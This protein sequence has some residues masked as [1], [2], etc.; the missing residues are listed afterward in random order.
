MFFLLFFNISRLR[1][2]LVCVLLLSLV[3]CSGGD[4][5]LPGSTGSTGSISWVAPSE[6]EDATVLSLSDIAGYRIYYGVETGNYQERVVINDPSA[7]QATIAGI[8][9]GTF[10][11]VITTVDTDGRESSWSTPELKVSF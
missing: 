11:A 8:P 1:H 9:S 10:F 2:L 5:G 6:R 7:T 3:A 4:G